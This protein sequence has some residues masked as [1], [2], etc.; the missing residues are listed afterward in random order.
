MN[1]EAVSYIMYAV[2]H[3]LYSII[4]IENVAWFSTEYL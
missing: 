3:V 4:S 2:Q 1:A